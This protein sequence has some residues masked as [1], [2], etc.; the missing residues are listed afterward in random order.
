VAL[1]SAL[2]AEGFLAYR[3]SDGDGPLF[4]ML[5]LDSYGKRA[6]QASNRTGEW[7]R[8]K[9]GITDSDKPLAGNRRRSTAF[10]RGGWTRSASLCCR[11]D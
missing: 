7:L 10:P 4:P 6:E 5:R 3:E 1:H 2:L 11:I 8:N 9:V